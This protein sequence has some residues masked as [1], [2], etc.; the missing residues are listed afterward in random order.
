M[1]PNFGSNSNYICGVESQRL[2][3]PKG[4]SFVKPAEERCLGG[5]TFPKQKWPS[6][7]SRAFNIF[8]IIFTK[9][10]FIMERLN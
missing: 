5:L 8:Y 6:R 2:T 4:F 9:T 7:V 1:L 10:S 3:H